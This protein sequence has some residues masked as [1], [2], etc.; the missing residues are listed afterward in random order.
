MVPH[1]A[2]TRIQARSRPFRCAFV[3]GLLLIPALPACNDTGD[4]IAPDGRVVET[5]SMSLA[6]P[7]G[8]DIRGIQALAH[9][10]ETAFTAN[11]AVAYGAAYAI[12]ADFVNPIGVLTA[13]RAALVAV[14]AAAFAGGFAGATL[15]A[16]LREVQFLTGTI[17][18]ADVYTTL[19]APAGTPPPWAVVSPDGKVRARARWLVEKHQGEWRILS[20]YHRGWGH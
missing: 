13:G 8:G 3:A 1:N 12:N 11:D 16:E 18:L 14:H 4:A 7:A 10:F 20:S 6:G 5:A 9:A 19:F 17:A 2:S 15:T